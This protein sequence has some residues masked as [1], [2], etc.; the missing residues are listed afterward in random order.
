M[1]KERQRRRADWQP[2]DS[3]DAANLGATVAVP[4]S[5]R[6]G[7]IAGQ[8]GLVEAGVDVARLKQ[9]GQHGRAKRLE[10][11]PPSMPRKEDIDSPK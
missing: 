1:G 3:A 4:S 7:T 11:S 8:P 10:L 9:A 6:A 2:A 5:N